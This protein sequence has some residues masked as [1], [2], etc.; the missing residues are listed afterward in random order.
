[1]KTF[2]INDNLEAV[3]D[4]LST[5]N[6]FKHTA[7]LLLNGIERESVKINYINRTWESFEYQSVLEKLLDKVGSLLSGDE[8]RDFLQN[9]L[10]K[11][12]EE[13]DAQF[14]TIAKIAKL[15]EIF[16]TTQKEKNDWKSRMIKAGLEGKGLIMPD[17]WDT[18]S[19]D[20]KEKRLNGVIGQLAGTA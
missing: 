14:G 12:T 20:D 10:K 7:T 2:K 4:S 8:K 1:M 9:A 18:L 11:N 17:D 13:L 3:C 15:G 6:G 5:R 16:G 19:E